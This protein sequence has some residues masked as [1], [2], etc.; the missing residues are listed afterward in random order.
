MKS[1]VSIT[2]LGKSSSGR[3]LLTSQICLD[4]IR[5]ENVRVYSM[6]LAVIETVD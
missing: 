6:F 3:E 1:L 4:A 5:R 2:A